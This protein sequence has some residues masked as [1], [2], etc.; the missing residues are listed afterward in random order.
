[1]KKFNANGGSRKDT[2]REL[3]AANDLNMDL[4]GLSL[5]ESKEALD[6]TILLTEEDLEEIKEKTEDTEKEMKL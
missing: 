2:T 5:E 1:M 6:D 4:K 3:N